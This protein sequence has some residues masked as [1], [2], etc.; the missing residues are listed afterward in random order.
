M[1]SIIIYVTRSSL[2]IGS[3]IGESTDEPGEVFPGAEF[4][5]RRTLG[6]G[7]CAIAIDGSVVS[8]RRRWSILRTAPYRS[9]T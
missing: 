2:R 7:S 6:A 9:R 4:S 5:G 8:R 3:G 1:V